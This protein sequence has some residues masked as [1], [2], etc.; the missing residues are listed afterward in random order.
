MPNQDQ[1]AL[2]IL[3]GELEMDTSFFD[4][5]HLPTFNDN[6][7]ISVYNA[8]RNG[9]GMIVINCEKYPLSISGLRRAIAYAFDKEEVITIH[10][11]GF[12]NTLDSVVPRCNGWCVEDEFPYHYYTAQPDIGNQILDDLNFTIDAET[13]Y[14]VAPD[15]SPFDIN[16]QYSSGCGGP[17]SRFAMFEALE[18]LHINY[19]GSYFGD[20]L[21]FIETINSHGDYDMFHWSRNFD[22]NNL[23]WLVDEFGSENAEVY[24]KNPCNFRN[25]TFDSWIDQLLTGNTY[26]EVYEAASEMQKILHYNVPNIIAYEST[27]MQAYRND[28][29]TGYVPDL[30]RYIPGLWT[31]RKIHHLDGSMGGTVAVSIQEALNSFNVLLAESS[32]SEVILEELYSSLYQAGPNGAPIQDLAT[33]LLIETHE[34]NPEV[35]SGHTRFTIDLIRNATWIDGMPLTADDVAFTLNYLQQ[36]VPDEKIVVWDWDLSHLYSIFNPT[37]YQ[38]VVEFLT[39]SYWNFEEFAYLKILP[40]HICTSEI[41]QETQWW[42]WNPGFNDEHPL[43]TSGPFKLSDFE[44]GEYYELSR[45]SDYYYRD[46]SLGTA[47]TSTTTNLTTTTSQLDIFYG[48]LTILLTAGFT[49]TILIV[50]VEIYRRRTSA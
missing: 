23:E 46:E 5:V 32:Y 9:Y 26:E 34:D 24:G 22:S 4:P 1:R 15:G 49:A 19:T 40:K 3:N 29:F 11:D 8:S 14:R 39:E 20:Y 50:T 25:T 42:N 33:S 28:R 43:V 30:H 37:T 47:T 7:N 27:Y 38:V 16:L 10:L 21:E 35:N 12:G 6:P 48:P 36:L 18:A 13:G 44:E 45:N 31:M 41:Y 2:A 17:V